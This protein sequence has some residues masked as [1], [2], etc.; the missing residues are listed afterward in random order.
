[1]LPTV[2]EVT[3]GRSA[4]VPPSA[5]GKGHTALCQGGTRETSRVWWKRGQSH[6]TFFLPEEGGSEV[7]REVRASVNR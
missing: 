6:R 2:G 7:L 4:A 5:R 1:M 3:G